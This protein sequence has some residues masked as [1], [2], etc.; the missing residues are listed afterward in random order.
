M[1]PDL[2]ELI[3]HAVGAGLRTVIST[4]GTLITAEKARVIKQTGVTY[5]GVSLDG[6]GAV[7][8]RFRGVEGA[9]DKAV[10]GIRHC[11]D[12]G[13]ARGPAADADPAQCAGPGA[14]VRLLRGRRHRAGL[15]LSS[16]AQRPRQR[17][18]CG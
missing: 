18:V 4:N 3:G 9:F 10:A 16:R 2:F 12:A 15:L 5:V 6:I 1:R 8:D 17:Y 13:R 11:M 7:N 14:I